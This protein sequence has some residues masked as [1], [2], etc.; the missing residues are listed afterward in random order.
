MFVC[1]AKRK[2]NYF[3]LLHF[4]VILRREFWIARKSQLTIY[5]FLF[6]AETGF[7]R[8]CPF[9]K[10]TKKINSICKNVQYMFFLLSCRSKHKFL[11]LHFVWTIP[12]N[13]MFNSIFVI[14]DSLRLWNLTGSV[15]GWSRGDDL[16]VGPPNLVNTDPQGL[17]KIVSYSG[18]KSWSTTKL[19]RILY[20][21]NSFPYRQ[22]LLKVVLW[23]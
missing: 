3:L 6:H 12:L 9:P 22:K 5:L 8:D 7:H 10:K 13:E 18:L 14:L 23:M 15:L 19:S 2:T 1:A 11:I 16:S 17:I 4:F 20:Y 21:I